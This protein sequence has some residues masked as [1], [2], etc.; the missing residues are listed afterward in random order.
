MAKEEEKNER[1]REREEKK[2]IGGCN[3]LAPAASAS[4]L[5]LLETSL[6]WF[7]IRWFVLLLLLLPSFCRT[8]P[9]SRNEM[10]NCTE[11]RSEQR[12]KTNPIPFFSLLFF[13]TQRERERERETCWER[14]TK[15]K[16][17]QHQQPSLV[18][19]SCSLSVSLFA[20]HLISPDRGFVARPE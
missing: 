17:T 18:L 13:I 2:K 8:R 6:R 16:Q 3:C 15:Q 11:S 12:R 7:V 20:C 4:F 1:E 19:V 9:L 5:I 14:K 10:T